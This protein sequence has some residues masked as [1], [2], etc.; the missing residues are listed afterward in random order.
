MIFASDLDQTLLF[1]ERTMKAPKAN[2][3]VSPV[4]W[5]DG[6][7]QSYM[8][9]TSSNLLKRI[10]EVA[11]FIPVTTRTVEQ[12]KRISY[13]QELAPTYAITSNG[14]TILVNGEPDREWSTKIETEILEQCA[15]AERILSAIASVGN[16]D[17]LLRQRQADGLFYYFIV[18]EDKLPYK[19]LDAIVA[20]AF[21]EGWTLTPQGKK[22]YLIPNP[23]RKERALAHVLAQLEDS[24]LVTS[25][26]SYLDKNMLKMADQAYIP[27]Q[28]QLA[29]QRG[30]V[31]GVIVTDEPGIFSSEQL[32]LDVLLMAQTNLD[33]PSILSSKAACIQWGID[34]STLR[35]RRED[36]PKG[37]I[38]KFGSSYAVTAKG[39]YTVFG[40]PLIRDSYEIMK[41]GGNS[42]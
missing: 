9:S 33:A 39:M 13:I 10:R 7:E 8:T 35:K 11:T 12:Y 31:R 36:F 2:V 41:E 3:Y 30:D 25:G 15:P 34:P 17:W 1:S 26:D 32:L 22:M 18:D 23:V 14:G 19:E 4:E 27:S 37:T 21:E 16:G 28:S 40:E 20:Y 29:T 42:K 5:I 38:R 6:K 24:F